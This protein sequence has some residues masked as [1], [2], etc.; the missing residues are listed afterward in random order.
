MDLRNFT[1]YQERIKGLEDT[2]GLSLASIRSGFVDTIEN[3]HCENLLGAITVPL[4]VAGPLKIH[5]SANNNIF[6]PLATTEGALVASV[7]RGC[8]V[9]AENEGVVVSIENVGTTR[10]SVFKTKGV[11]EGI[12][13]SEW[14][15]TNVPELKQVAATTSKHL[16][17]IKVDTRVNAQE[18]YVRFYFDTDQAMG[19]NMATIASDKIIQ[20][21]QEKL[22]ITCIAIAGNFDIDKKPAWLNFIDGRGKRGWAEICISKDS[23]INILKTT[24]EKI[25]EVV[26]SKCWEGS[27]MSGSLGFNAHYANIV[28]A[29]FVATGQDVAHVVEG[30]HGITSARILPN[31]DLYFSIMM[32][33]IM[34]GMVG[35]GTKLKTQ[36]EARSIT[37]AKNTNE[38]VSVLLGAVLA[39][40]LSLIASIAA[41]SLAK[42]HKT[43]GR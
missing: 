12:S 2:L 13:A 32:P 21:I 31:G 43:L 38:L 29:F 10:G 30:S 24:P 37:G 5:D 3:V 15:H 26:L 42:A 33:A 25:V 14:I 19:M 7:N 40:E 35:G 22:S 27:I 41:H 36:T 39:G 28:A 1:N 23:V 18:L 6:I 8:K 34:I 9:I 20:Y 17:L 11:R 4:G 16:D